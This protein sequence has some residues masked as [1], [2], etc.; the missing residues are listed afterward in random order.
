M[1]RSRDIHDWVG[2]GLEFAS[3]LQIKDNEVKG[4]EDGKRV[5]EVIKYRN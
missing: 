5:D 2:G 4:T 3:Q 1:Y